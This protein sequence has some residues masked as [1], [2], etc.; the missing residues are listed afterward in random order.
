MRQH[1]RPI[2]FSS[3]PVIL[4]PFPSCPSS[5]HVQHFYPDPL[6]PPHPSHIILIVTSSQPLSWILLTARSSPTS[7][8]ASSPSSTL[9][10]ASSSQAPALFAQQPGKQEGCTICKNTIYVWPAQSGETG[11]P[12]RLCNPSLPYKEE[13]EDGEDEKETPTSSQSSSSPCR[14]SWST[15]LA[16][17]SHS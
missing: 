17:Q 1:P 7:L 10:P 12:Y 11:P 15:Q 13:E 8:W 5:S 2:I 9:A 3:L 4:S 16:C 6:Y 14:P